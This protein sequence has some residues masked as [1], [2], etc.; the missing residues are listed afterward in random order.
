MKS[1][2]KADR[3]PIALPGR[4]VT[5]RNERALVQGA[6]ELLSLSWGGPSPA[7]P[8]ALPSLAPISSTPTPGGSFL[9]PPLSFLH[10]RV[11]PGPDTPYSGSGLEPVRNQSAPFTQVLILP[12][13][14]LKDQGAGP[15]R[16]GLASGQP[17]GAAGKPPSFV[18]LQPLRQQHTQLSGP[19]SLT[20]HLFL[21]PPSWAP[22]PQL[23]PT[24]PRHL[25]SR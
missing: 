25:C 5:C 21:V 11:T 1:R 18:P 16:K 17:W 10:H 22:P 23:G 4:T 13:G 3:V 8:R 6:E 7:P 20:P 12:E 9:S 19:W 15:L 14:G 24:T 2:R